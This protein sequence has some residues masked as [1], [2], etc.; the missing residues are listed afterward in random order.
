MS[1]C[2]YIRSFCSHVGLPES[3]FIVLITHTRDHTHTHSHAHA[4]PQTRIYK[5][6]KNADV[7]F[8]VAQN[9]NKKKINKKIGAPFKEVSSGWVRYFSKPRNETRVIIYT[10]NTKPNRL[11]SITIHTYLIYYI[12]HTLLSLLR[13]IKPPLICVRICIL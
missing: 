6:K 7:R 2:E 12:L 3:Y 8:V 11:S 9:N 4:E 13:L 1:V 5:E 10:L